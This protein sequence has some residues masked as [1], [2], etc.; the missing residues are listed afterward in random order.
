MFVNEEQLYRGEANQSLCWSLTRIKN[1]IN[2]HP[3][4]TRM[5]GPTLHVTINNSESVTV[6]CCAFH[7]TAP[8]SCVPQTSVFKLTEL[9]SAPNL[10][11][12]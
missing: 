1:L 2:L 4:Y 5:C 11:W 3:D 12:V 10:Y 9:K 8:V 6:S 7:N